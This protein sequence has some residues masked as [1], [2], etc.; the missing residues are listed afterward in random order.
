MNKIPDTSAQDLQIVPDKS[1]KKLYLTATIV[2]MLA[3][4]SFYITPALSK[5]SSSEYTVSKERLRTAIVDRGSFTRDVSVQARVVAAV[6]PVLYSPAQGTVTYLVDAGDEVKKNQTLSVIESPELQSEYNQQL[7]S[8]VRLQ[9][10]LDRQKIQS[11]TAI[12]SKEK[13]AD[14]AKVLLNA[15]TREMRRSDVANNKSLIS[16]IDFQKAKDDLE[17]AQ[18]EYQHVLKEAKLLDESLKFEVKSK[19]L[20]A[21][22]QQVL[23]DELQRQVKAL[24]I[25]SPVSGLVG[26]LSAEQKN[27][28]AKNQALLN[29]VDLSRFELELGIPENYADDLALGMK[30]QILFNNDHYEGTLVA[31]APEII[32]NQVQGKIRFSSRSP[33]GL[34]QN[35]RLTTRILLEEKTDVLYLP[36]GQFLDS[37]G[38]R[39]AYVVND[40]I[41][42]KMK[43]TTGAR[44]LS[45]VEISNG[46]N[47]GD[48]VVISNTEQ[49]QGATQVV[50]TQ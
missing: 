43:I 45:K 39:V 48:E 37:N 36:R 9:T 13:D 27:A 5:W 7:A 33:I 10:Q 29:V 6:R 22:S 15:A 16:D 21:Q 47:I 12:L 40:D 38:G 30:A 19:E 1:Y 4:S 49:F 20:E 23:V 50:I 14:K 25:I 17:N 8:L 42:H 26:N 32:N 3:A 46:L 24:N 41:A 28:V 18:L 11:K 35:Q 44:S 34:R 31:I 2:A